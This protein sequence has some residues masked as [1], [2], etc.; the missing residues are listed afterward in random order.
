MLI[1][2]PVCDDECDTYMGSGVTVLIKEV[3][4]GAI[5][6]KVLTLECNSCGKEIFSC[7]I[8]DIGRLSTMI[9]EF[10]ASRR[11]SESDAL[12]NENTLLRRKLEQLEELALHMKNLAKIN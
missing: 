5:T 7:F 9:S 12:M 8:M 2:C 3:K 6:E 10:L 11:I 1:R 4:E